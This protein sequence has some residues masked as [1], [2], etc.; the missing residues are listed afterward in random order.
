[1]PIQTAL[2]FNKR[3][4]IITILSQTPR[5]PCSYAACLDFGLPALGANRSPSSLART[6]LALRCTADGARAEVRQG[7]ITSGPLHHWFQA[8]QN[9][10]SGDAGLAN[11]AGILLRAHDLW[12]YLGGDGRAGPGL[13]RPFIEL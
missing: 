11:K 5:S 3:L 10:R 7:S 1:M 9:G 13:A 2:T 12:E 6:A 4:C 8:A